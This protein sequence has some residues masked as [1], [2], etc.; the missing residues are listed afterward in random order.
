MCAAGTLP[1]A[2]RID[3]TGA[4]RAAASGATRSSA[5]TGSARARSSR[6]R[7]ACSSRTLGKRN[8]SAADR[9]RSNH[10]RAYNDPVHFSLRMWL[11]VRRQSPNGL[12]VPITMTHQLDGSAASEVARPSPTIEAMRRRI[13]RGWCS[14]AAHGE[15]AHYAPSAGN[16]SRRKKRAIFPPQRVDSAGCRIYEGRHWS[17]IHGPPSA[18]LMATA[19]RAPFTLAITIRTSRDTSSARLRELLPV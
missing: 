16:A 19:A 2:V 5:R 9:Q 18:L 6:T 4:T 12:N 8:L 13:W 3:I 11:P 10:G 7:A 14:L 15:I 1:T 17:H